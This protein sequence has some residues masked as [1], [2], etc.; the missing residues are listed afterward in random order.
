MY[1]TINN[2]KSEKRIDLSYS[3][4]NF[5][6]GKERLGTSSAEIAVIRML[7]DNVQCEILK[8]RA[9]MDPISNTKK[10]IP[11]GTY[12]GRELISMLEGIIELNQFEV[13]DQVTKTNKLKG[14]TEITLNLDELNNSDNLKNGRPSNELLT[15]HMTSNEDFTCFEPQ[16]PQ[17][18]K[19][20][21]REFTSL[22]LRI[23][24]QNN[25][26]IT[27]GL[28][29]TVVLHIRNRKI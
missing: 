25:N 17:Y 18:K 3:I 11:S 20:K 9:V 21:N 23:T 22:T 7:S 16:T 19:L 2:I 12:A 29:V 1:I 24:D 6:S 8:L 14:I 15:Y 10:I 27:D 4:Q 28:Q 26:I 5:D 13:D